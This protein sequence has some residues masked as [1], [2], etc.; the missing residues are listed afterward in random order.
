M[1][2]ES[3]QPL[4]PG[5][6]MRS[7]P[8]A[9]WTVTESGTS[10]PGGYPE[11]VDELRNLLDHI[12][13][14]VPSAAMVREITKLVEEVNARLLPHEVP[15][16][17]QVSGQLTSIPGRARLLTPVYSVDELDDRAMPGRVRFGRHYLG[18]NGAVHGGAIPLLFDD[19]LGRLALVGG[20]AKSRTAY[21]NVDYRSVTPID[22]ELQIECWFDREEGRKRFL[23]GI[24]RHGDRLCAEASGLFVVLRPGQP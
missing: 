16:H 23:R 21:L 7:D 11:M 14:A 5:P 8:Q 17:D 12:A 2:H 4:A 13:A 9:E 18:S 24:L 19:A 3:W 1:N 22:E 15:E 6:L 20:R 10:V